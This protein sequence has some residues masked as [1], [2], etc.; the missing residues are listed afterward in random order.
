[1]QSGVDDDGEASS[2][3]LRCYHP[4]ATTEEYLN[5]IGLVR[6]TLTADMLAE[7]ERGKE[8]FARL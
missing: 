5:A 1:M 4:G 6:P 7:F 2:M 3:C 8:D